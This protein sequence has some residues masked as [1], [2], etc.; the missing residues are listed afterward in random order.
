MVEDVKAAVR[1]KV[2]RAEIRDDPF[3]HV[4]IPDLLPE[5]FFRRLSDTVPPLESFDVSRTG[6]KADMPLLESSE[7]FR[8]APADFREAW[9]ALKDEVVREA[10]APVLVGRLQEAIRA[11]YVDLLS[12]ELANKIMADGLTSAD[13]R[14]MARRPGYHLRPHLDSAHFAITCLLYFTTAADESSGALCLFRPDRMPEQLDVS[15]Y[16]PERAEGIAVELVDEIPIRENMFVAFLNRRDAL[17]G[18]RIDREASPGPHRL[19]YQVHILPKVD[20]RKD[21]ES[22]ADDLADP[23]ARLRW[24]RYVEARK[25]RAAERAAAG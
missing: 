4:V 9:I 19:T 11:K 16:Y 8:D 25:A 1:E 5:A 13:G 10:I 7:C 23:A 17:H 2:E 21:A 14:I 6:L 15:T 20:V 22:F 24:Q 3:P 12:P 18:V